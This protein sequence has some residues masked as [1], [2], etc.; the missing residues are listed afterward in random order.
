WFCVCCDCTILCLLICRAPRC[1][2]F[3]YTTLFR[4]AEPERQAVGIVA[5]YSVPVATLAVGG[6]DSRQLWLG[7]QV[8]A[9]L[10]RRRAAGGVVGSCL[11]CWSRP[12]VPAGM[13]RVPHLVSVRQGAVITDVAV[14]ELTD[15]ESARDRVGF[16]VDW[17]FF[18]ARLPV[19]LRLRAACRM[20]RF[21]L[22]TGHP[23]TRQWSGEGCSGAPYL[24][25]PRA[26]P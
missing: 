5:C 1:S 10:S 8:A 4:S 14:W 21:P 17:E 11:T 3:P 12:V 7:L 24:E 22:G 23:E 25:L 13:V 16:P 20:V 18:E 19:L 9:G 6:V 26:V 15:A 2:F